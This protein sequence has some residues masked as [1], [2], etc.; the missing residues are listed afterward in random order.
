MQIEAIDLF[1][2]AG[3][4]SYGL[5]KAGIKVKGGVDFD[6]HCKYPFEKNIKG[7]FILADIT[8]VTAADLE[9]M[10]T[11]GALRLLAGCA[12]C[13]PFSTLAH[14]KDNSEDAKWSLLDEFSR[15]IREIHPEFVSMENVPRVAN[16][17]PFR[18]FITTLAELGYHVDWRRIR[19]ADFGVPQERRRFVLVA[20]RLG[21]I[22]LPNSKQK[23]IDVRKAI[24]HLP[25]LKAGEAD[26]EDPLHKARALN[27]INL[28]R[29]Q[30]STQGGTWMDWPEELRAKCHS[31]KS[32]AS[33][34]S[35]Y[36]RMSWDKPAPTITT[37]CFNFGTGR[38]GHPEQ[39]RGITLR[40]AA[41]LQSF[42]DKY[43][44]I[45]PGRDV[46][47]SIVG[48]LIG[49]AVP[50][51]LGQMVGNVFKEHINIIGV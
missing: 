10:Y 36:A 16:H 25:K 22:K 39:N 32:G 15:L 49:N 31:T 3:G 12:P 11:P 24:G 13:Q 46:P 19:C 17:Q 27:E 1:C 20:S 38:F 18:D 41:I 50:P 35:V 2:G 5:K 4:L 51:K 28:K 26:A 9:R 7:Q 47:F 42:P 23:E 34:K 45:E 33:F 29:I 14:G 21:E 48:R 30:A 6:A 37:Q 40:E 43:E 44:F 8:T